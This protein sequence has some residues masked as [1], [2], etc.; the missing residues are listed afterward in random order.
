MCIARTACDKYKFV[1]H[2]SMG[3]GAKVSGFL[4]NLLGDEDEE[5]VVLA[6][7]GGQPAAS[8]SKEAAPPAEEES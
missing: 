1:A 2:P 8:K 4:S 7:T 3:P 6:A 5:D